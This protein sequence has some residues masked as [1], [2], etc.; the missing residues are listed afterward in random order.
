MTTRSRILLVAVLAIVGVGYLVY[1]RTANKRPAPVPP[2]EQARVGDAFAA[3]QPEQPTP[4]EP[5]SVP[6]SPPAT[7]KKTV[8]PFR[9]VVEMGK[10]FVWKKLGGDPAGIPLKEQLQHLPVWPDVKAQWKQQ[11]ETVTPDTVWVIS[12]T[13]H[14]YYLDALTWGGRYNRVFKVRGPVMIDLRDSTGA[15]IDSVQALQWPAVPHENEDYTLMQFLACTN[16]AFTKCVA[17]PIPPKA[18]LPP[19]KKIPPEDEIPPPTEEIPPGEEELPPDWVKNGTIWLT[20]E[21]VDG[22]SNGDHMNEFAGGEFIVRRSYSPNNLGL[23]VRAGNGVV[24]DSKAYGGQHRLGLRVPV[25]SPDF[26]S[27]QVEAGGYYEPQQVV[28]RDYQV[29]SPTKTHWQDRREMVHGVGGYLR[30]V[31]YGPELLYWDVV[32]RTGNHLDHE[33]DADASAAPA[34]ILYT[35]VAFKETRT[36]ERELHAGDRTFAFPKNIMTIREA[37]LGVKPKNNHTLYVGWNDWKYRSPSWRFDW[38]GPS[39]GWDWRVNLNWRFVTD[40]KTFGKLGGTTKDIDPAEQKTYE[41]DHTRIAAGLNYN[42]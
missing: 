19:E 10:P 1:T 3:L 35:K 34:G 20:G 28:W 27:F 41:N 40:V 23:V 12:T 17:L 25:Y 26:W 31:G 29:V 13:E 15:H 21:Y 7:P 4:M 30:T 6:P 2:S 5:M 18:E 8:E 33:F 32:G 9:V 11:I 42:F 37:R 38:S 24:E 16:G 36:D 39:I 22:H 14:P